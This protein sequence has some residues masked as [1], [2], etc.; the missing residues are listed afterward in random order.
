MGEKVTFLFKISMEKG[1]SLRK[2]DG[3]TLS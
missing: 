3:L 1:N 2:G